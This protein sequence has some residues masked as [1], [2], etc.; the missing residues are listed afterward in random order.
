VP[1]GSLDQY[2]RFEVPG[3][4]AASSTQ[5]ESSWPPDD[6]LSDTTEVFV[7]V[8]GCTCTHA[9]GGANLC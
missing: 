1:A 2:R 9:Y 7:F 3:P 6:G 4:Q 8:F 5:F